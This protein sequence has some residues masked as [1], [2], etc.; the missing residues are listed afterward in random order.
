MIDERDDLDDMMRDLMQEAGLE[1]APSNFT[2]AVMGQIA[3]ETA[4][5]KPR[6]KP[7]ISLRGWIAIGTG[8]VA[9]SVAAIVLLQ[10]SNRELPGKEQVQQAVNQASSMM[11]SINV[12]T[13]L[14]L[15]ATAIAALFMLDRMLTRRQNNSI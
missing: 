5:A 12:P 3:A 9:S 8:L 1:R 6:W 14:A 2:Q 15:S 10:P 7:I 13:I 11:E 4:K